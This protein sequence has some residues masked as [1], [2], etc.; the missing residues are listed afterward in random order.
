MLNKSENGF[1]RDIIQIC[2]GCMSKDQMFAEYLSTESDF[3][4]ILM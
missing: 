4:E 2:F 1:L 3:I